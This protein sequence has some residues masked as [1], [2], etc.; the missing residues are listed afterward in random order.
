MRMRKRR[1]LPATCPR[2]VWPLSSWT[3]N[4][5]FGSASTTSPSNSTFSSF[6]TRAGRYSTA[7]TRAT[8][9]AA[10]LREVAVERRAL[11]R[12]L[13][14]GERRA[15]ALALGRHLHEVVPDERG[16]SAAEHLAIGRHVGHRRRA[17]GIADPHRRVQ[18]AG[19]A[20]EP[21]V[22]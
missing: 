21:R 8:A 19:E 13:R 15:A 3:R 2:T 17:L 12:R 4:M 14:L 9:L 16:R 7:R 5:A 1:I 6:A 11:E 10:A 22:G 20:V 18:A